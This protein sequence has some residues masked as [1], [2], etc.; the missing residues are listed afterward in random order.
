MSRPPPGPTRPDTLFPN[1]TLLRSDRAG[2]DAVPRTQVQERPADE[3]VGGAEQL[4]HADFL[5]PRLDV[6]AHRVAHHQQ[7]AQVEQ[8]C[9]HP[10]H[11][12]A[13]AQP[14]RSEETT[15]ELQ[16]LMRNSYAVFCLKKQ[17]P[18]K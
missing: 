8:E 1:T 18:Y 9:Q 6:Q 15:S 13:K 2:A 4:Q 14:A 5:A 10:S 11:A 3:S 12:A 7:R 17:K 16:S